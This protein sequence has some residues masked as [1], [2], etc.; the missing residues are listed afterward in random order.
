MWNT[1]LAF[2]LLKVHI[3]VS[4]LIAIVVN[5]NH[6]YNYKELSQQNSTH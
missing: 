2:Y 4:P 6:L 1:F 3:G 5:A